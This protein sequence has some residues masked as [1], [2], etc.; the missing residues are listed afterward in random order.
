MIQPIKGVAAEESLSQGEKRVA[1]V[2]VMRA[3][4][5][6][7]IALGHALD[8]RPTSGSMLNQYVYSFHVP[9]FFF[10]S[11]LLFR[12]K[13]ESFFAFTVKKFKSLMIPYYIFSI[14]SILIFLVLGSVASDGLGVAVKTTDL[15][16]NLWGMLYGNG[17]TGYMKWNLPLWFVPCLFITLLIFYWIDRVVLA[18]GKR[19]SRKFIG[20]MVGSLAL[21][22][23]N[24]YVLGIQKL[25]FGLETAV[26]ML[27]FFVVGYWTGRTDM[28]S[29][30]QSG[31]RYGLGAAFVIAGAILAFVNGPR[32]GYVGSAYNNLA[33]YYSSAMLSTAGAVMLLQTASNKLLIYVGRNTLPILLMHKFPIVFFQMFLVDTMAKNELLGVSIAIVIAGASCAMALL[34]GEVIRRIAPFALGR[35]RKQN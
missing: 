5:M 21:S 24:Y 22:F 8:A 30:L 23:L 12:G 19:N 3:V 27:P 16:P 26:Y 17:S 10:L 34:A 31:V 13:K 20:M 25:P 9:A 6:F 4:M 33:V 18:D 1:W 15:L 7:A 35:V 29:K 2:D 28:L 32:V 14:L 11:G